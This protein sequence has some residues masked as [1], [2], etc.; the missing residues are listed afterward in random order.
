[1]NVS[2][3]DKTDQVH[4]IINTLVRCI[5]ALQCRLEKNRFCQEGPN[6][7]YPQYSHMPDVSRDNQ[8]NPLGYIKLIIA[9]YDLA[10]PQSLWPSSKNNQISSKALQYIEIE[11]KHNPYIFLFFL[12]YL[13]KPIYNSTTLLLAT[14]FNTISITLLNYFR[15]YSTFRLAQIVRDPFTMGTLR[16]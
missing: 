8:P 2:P 3:I 11:A 10:F 16:T 13:L 14:L 12:F 9:N 7:Q 1:M 5:R 4:N 15:S 6:R